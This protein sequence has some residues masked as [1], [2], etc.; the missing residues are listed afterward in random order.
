VVY[1]DWRHLYFVYPNLLLFSVWS[2][3]EILKNPKFK[4]IFFAFGF[5][6]V[7][8]SLYQIIKLHPQQQTYFNAFAGKNTD[9]DYDVDYW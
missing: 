2:I 8:Y 6:S 9:E 5:I 7:S 4:T 1:D 3:S